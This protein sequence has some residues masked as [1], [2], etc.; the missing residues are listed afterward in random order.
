[1]IQLR[2][3]ILAVALSAFACASFAREPMHQWA[4]P[5][6]IEGGK[7]TTAMVWVPPKAD[8]VRG[9]LIGR[10]PALTGDPAVRK[11]CEAEK[12]AIINV[13]I[14]AVFDYK[15][16]HGPALFLATLKA[17]AEATGYGEIEQAPFFAFGHSVASIYA[18]SAAAWKPDRCFGTVPFKGGLVYPPAWDP[19]ADLSG[20]PI[21][22]ISG[23]FEEFGPGP[24]GV[25]RDFE[26]RDSGWQVGRLNYLK[27]RMANEK[28]L[29]AFAVE[30]GTTHMAW[31]P[32]DGEL[33]GLFLRKAAQVRIP[34]W[35]ADAKEPVVCKTIDVTS[36]AL[37]SPGI[38][39]PR[40]PE[41]AAYKDYPDKYQSRRNAAWWH[42]DLE[43]ANAWRAF[44][45][46]RFN[47]RDQYVT[48]A[49]PKT[50]KTL[51]SRHDLRFDIQPHWVGADTFKV[52]GAFLDHVRDK[53]PVPNCPI[54]HAEGPIRFHAFGGAI[55]QVGEDTFRVTGYGNRGGSGSIVAYHDGDEA[56][57][58]A[59]QP[60]RIRL[61]LLTKGKVQKI[62]FPK[63]PDAMPGET[64]ELKATVDSGLPVRYVV[65]HGP[66]VV[67]DGKLV[68]RG[69]PPKAKLPLEVIVTAYQWGSA[70][71]PFVQTAESV[72]RTLTVQSPEGR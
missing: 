53:Y 59:E 67:D 72:T 55:E 25:L 57:R 24:S 36:G 42:P 31:S 48:F 8:R 6:E 40:A 18:S 5:V 54:R 61:P 33:V 9:V 68:I 51:Y 26:D 34:D 66:A 14:D 56:F 19:K 63:L 30:A 62:A 60:A 52:A 58:Y 46:R 12:L 7:K 32:R 71:E 37:S 69:I 11:A 64:I 2:V 23:Q 43:M 29:I 22:V 38:T 49:D 70:V 3:A 20:V 13:S 17:V 45:E 16:G 50:G 65:N 35:P 28:M 44:H 41:P 1:M 39:N 27:M 15:D 10:M 4:V 21:L 47:K